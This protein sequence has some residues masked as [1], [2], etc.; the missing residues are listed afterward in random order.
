MS[1]NVDSLKIFRQAIRALDVQITQE[2]LERYQLSN[3][4]AVVSENI[5]EQNEDCREIN[6]NCLEQGLGCKKAINPFKEKLLLRLR[7]DV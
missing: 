3:T 5:R 7:K 2:K 4:I 1:N 6:F